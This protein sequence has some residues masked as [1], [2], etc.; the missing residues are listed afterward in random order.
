[1]STCG[2]QNFISV[3]GDTNIPEGREKFESGSDMQ[4][5]FYVGE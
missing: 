5:K 1:M 4:K 2:I 3:V